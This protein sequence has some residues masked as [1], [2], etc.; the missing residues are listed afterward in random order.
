MVTHLTLE[1]SKTNCCPINNAVC[2]AS[3]SVHQ[4]NI[5]NFQPSLI[6]NG[7]VSHLMGP[8]VAADEEDSTFAQ[9]LAINGILL[10]N[11]FYYIN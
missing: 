5:Q 4:P 9:Y 8:S 7:H 6:F 3:L 1:F 11:S 10:E 2:L